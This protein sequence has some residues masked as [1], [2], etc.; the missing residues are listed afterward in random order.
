MK[1]K[2]N[3]DII[4]ITIIVALVAGLAQ[5]Y[6]S[7]NF[8]PAWE[9]HRAREVKVYYSKEVAA[10][11]LL[12]DQILNAKKYVHFS[13]YTFTMPDIKDALIAAKYRG[14]E[15]KGIIDKEQTDKIDA[16][17]AIVKELRAAGIPIGFQDHSA[18]MHLKVL[19]T[20]QSYV[21]GSYNWTAS[22]TD[23]NDEV[24]EV[25]RDPELRIQYQKL[26]NKMFALY[27]P[28]L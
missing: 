16:Q 25:S 14:L 17:K 3:R 21:S 6:F 23:K 11:E 22:A 7:L 8:Q 18:I 26:L 1:L 12:I 9:D 2:F 4:Y 24:I 27:P 15:V 13:I 19:V 28:Q 5:L 20:D 10:N